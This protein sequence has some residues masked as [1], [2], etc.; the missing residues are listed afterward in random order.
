MHSAD[1]SPDFAAELRK[2]TKLRVLVIHFDEMDEGMQKV[3]VESLCR[4]EKLQ[5][6]QIWFDTKGKV[7]L[8]GW[9]GSVPN[10]EL[11]QLLLFGVIL[12]N[13]T[14]WIHHLGARKLSKLVLQVETLTAQ[15]LDILGQMPLLRSLYLHSEK[16]EYQLYQLSYT[17][18]KNEFKV[19][20]YLN[21]NIELICGDGALPVI[22]E[23]EVGGI[24]PWVDVGLRGNMP[25]L[26]R[27][28]YHLNCVESVPVEVQ[29]AEEELRR[30]A[31]AHRNHPK[32]SIKRWNNSFEEL[33]DALS[34]LIPRLPHSDAGRRPLPSEDEIWEAVHRVG[35]VGDP[36]DNTG[37]PS[38]T[39]QGSSRQVHV[40]SD[41][42]TD[43]P[44]MRKSVKCLQLTLGVCIK[45]VCVAQQNGWPRY[46]SDYARMAKQIAPRMAEETDW[47]TNTRADAE[48]KLAGVSREPPPKLQVDTESVVSWLN[49]PEG[50]AFVSEGAAAVNID[51][52]PFARIFEKCLRNPK[53]TASMSSV[54]QNMDFSACLA[55]SR[56]RESQL[57]WWS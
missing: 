2:L 50:A 20:E 5:V 56:T 54:A 25:R 45:D 16:G 6:L 35:P 3:L 15:H 40:E 10:P 38:Q 30:A 11:H 46:I 43:A 51:P 8:G 27:A 23:L 13:Q 18:N 32:V 28:T 34:T 57:S 47:L 12:S 21:T 26:E 39:V 48:A 7:R 37:S 42:A 29:K 4:L 49:T 55:C 33:Q 41:A 44:A 1:K 19:L 31:A 24:R 22:R 9:E 36:T 52:V 14:P 53:M 17:A